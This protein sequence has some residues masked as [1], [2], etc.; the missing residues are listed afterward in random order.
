M[1]KWLLQ[2]TVPAASVLITAYLLPGVDVR[3]FGHAILVALTLGFLNLFVKPVL[4][5]LTIPITLLTL[6]FFLIILDA[7]MVLAAASLL[8]G[9]SVRNI[10]WAILFAFIVSFVSALLNSLFEDRR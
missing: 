9:F 1:I 2:L 4:E 5:I 8:D 3:S 7:L 6:G 10:G